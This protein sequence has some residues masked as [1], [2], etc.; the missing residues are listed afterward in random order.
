VDRLLHLDQK[1]PEHR[2][3]ENARRFVHHRFLKEKRGELVALQILYRLPY[4]ERRLTDQALDDLKEA[5][6]RPPGFC[7]RPTSGAL[8]SGLRPTRCAA[9]RPARSPTS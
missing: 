2:V 4:A 7:S 3:V 6:K 1:A 5:M 8:T 9:I